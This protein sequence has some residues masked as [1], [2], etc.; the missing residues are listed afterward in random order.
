VETPAQHAL[1]RDLACSHAQ[2]YLFG[3]PLPAADQDPGFAVSSAAGLS[4]LRATG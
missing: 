2:G 3:R 4:G 1:L